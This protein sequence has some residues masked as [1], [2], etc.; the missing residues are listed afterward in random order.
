MII[1]VL[2][3]EEVYLQSQ[4]QVFRI[5]LIMNDKLITLRGRTD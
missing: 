4:Q 2:D 5:L 1:I 3:D